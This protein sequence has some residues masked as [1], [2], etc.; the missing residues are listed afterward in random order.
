MTITIPHRNRVAFISFL[1]AI[2]ILAA[3]N[4]YKPLSELVLN[5]DE[6]DYTL[7]T[8][9]PI[10][11]QYLG[12][13]TIS[14]SEFAKLGYKK[15]KGG[16]LLPASIPESKDNFL[17]RHFH[18]ILP[19]YFLKAFQDDEADST[20]KQK[21]F[22]KAK[23][24][25]FV[26]FAISFLCL[27]LLYSSDTRSFI[28]SLAVSVVFLTT[29]LTIEP[30]YSLN[31]HSFFALMLVPFSVIFC[32]VFSNPNLKNSVLLAIISGLLLNILETASIVIF[33]AVLF[34]YLGGKIKEVVSS[35]AISAFFLSVLAV[36]P[37]QLI[38]LDIAK[39]HLMYVYRILVKGNDEYSSVGALGMFDR[40]LQ[41]L[42]P[43][44]LILCA[45]IVYRH[46]IRQV[47]FS[48]TNDASLFIGFIYIIFMTPF[49]LN[50]SYLLP[51]ITL[52]AVWM[53]KEAG[54][55]LDKA[56]LSSKTI[57]MLFMLPIVAAVIFNFSW[58]HESAALRYAKE[59]NYSKQFQRDLASLKSSI[60]KTPGNGLIISEIHN[61]LK[62]YT[63]SNNFTQGHIADG[64]VLI[65][66]NSEYLPIDLVTNEHK[67]NMFVFRKNFFKLDINKYPILKECNGLD[68]TEQIFVQ[69]KWCAPSQ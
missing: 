46:F 40:I 43:F 21:M 41:P 13:S 19:I 53:I 20:G 39:S 5:Y 63:G 67:I 31:F 33:C 12:K 68:S 2:V 50:P 58:V 28:M 8:N 16:D 36:Y 64:T 54:W 37:G 17:L 7:A 55:L 38:S 27:P 23:V 34:L 62:F 3:I 51:G 9:E 52:I 44:I 47:K 35:P 25:L 65:R 1:S 69:V 45:I 56:K 32:K 61:I 6:I 22:W 30:F 66:M 29:P 42:L 10:D 57:S 14:F 59:S 60:I 26:I 15:I 24:S 18:G 48:L 4:I 11:R 49:L